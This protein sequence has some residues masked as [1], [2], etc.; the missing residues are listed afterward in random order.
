MNLLALRAHR[1]M[2]FTR[3]VVECAEPLVERYAIAAIVAFEV[4][5]MKI[6][7]VVTRRR[8][9]VIPLDDEILKTGVAQWCH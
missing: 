1:L 8:N 2:G 5:V 3:A 6:M 4:A 7:K 9:L